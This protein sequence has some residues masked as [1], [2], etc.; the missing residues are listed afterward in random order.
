[1]KNAEDLVCRA[2]QLAFSF[3]FE[4]ARWS[5]LEQALMVSTDLGKVILTTLGGVIAVSAVER[6]I[7]CRDATREPRY[8]FATVNPVSKAWARQSWHNPLLLRQ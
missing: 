8:P 6:A 7:R 5:E 3:A 4:A 1:M 2:R